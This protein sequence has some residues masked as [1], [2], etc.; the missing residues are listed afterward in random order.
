MAA[1]DNPL[2]QSLRLPP[3]A[4]SPPPSHLSL[5]PTNV[6]RVV[7]VDFTSTIEPT[8]RSSVQW[9]AVESAVVACCCTYAAVHVPLAVGDPGDDPSHWR[10]AADVITWI[11]FVLD[12]WRAKRDEENRRLEKARS[13]DA[14]LFEEGKNGWR[15]QF[16]L[17]CDAAAVVPVEPFWALRPQFRQG[18]EI[19][20]AVRVAKIPRCTVRCYA[21]GTTG[22]V[23]CVSLGLLWMTHVFTVVTIGIQT[24]ET[25]LNY[26][27]AFYWVVYTLTS[28][29][30]GDMSVGHSHS[31]LYFA[32][33]L[34]VLG[35][36]G[37]GLF[38]GKMA[39]LLA[40]QDRTSSDIDRGM[41]EMASLMDYYR[42]PAEL[43][44]ETL[45]WQ[46]HVLST[47][48]FEHHASAIQNLPASM[49]QR[50]ALCARRRILEAVPL[51]RGL[52]DTCLEDLATGLVRVTLDPGEFLCSRGEFASELFFLTHGMM[53]LLNAEHYSVG[54][55]RQGD[56]WGELGVLF[57]ATY[58][59]SVRAIG[60]CD[61]LGVPRHLAL[62]CCVRYPEFS[63]RLWRNVK[64]VDGAS[65]H[66][67]KLLIAE[68]LRSHRRAS[69]MMAAPIAEAQ[70]IALD[71][72]QEMT[73]EAEARGNEEH[74][75]TLGRMSVD[76]PTSAISGF[77]N[78]LECSFSAHMLRRQSTQG[79]SDVD[80]ASPFAG[81]RLSDPPS[82][83][84]ATRQ[85]VTSLLSGFK[86]PSMLRRYPAH[87]QTAERR[88]TNKVQD[89]DSDDDGEVSPV[90]GLH[91]ALG[92][93]R[94]SLGAA[95]LNTLALGASTARRDTA[96]A[97][98]GSPHNAVSAAV[99]Q[100]VT[101]A[102][103]PLLSEIKSLQKK[104]RTMEVPSRQR[105]ECADDVGAVPNEPET[106]PGGEEPGGRQAGVSLFSVMRTH[107][108][109][110]SAA[111]RMKPSV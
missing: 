106:S 33:F 8:R 73:A 67:D 60:Y 109:V 34:M 97:L 37:S 94:M 38:I 6:E 2:R 64:D 47:H 1:P 81:G 66:S 51:L 42:I 59:V 79:S 105:S 39:E 95:Q 35:L 4:S 99:T 100:A 23:V 75:R 69:E 55:I 65:A 74:T 90:S 36:F 49:Q 24:G 76:L 88:H 54:S 46:A 72:L 5:S 111:L 110:K 108:G 26:S 12:L 86:M 107:G 91:P 70:V 50:I 102:V 71:V 101:A 29:G 22:M 15:E 25:S 3:R 52:S 21:C 41:A 48:A 104:I 63:S 19:M 13:A 18:Y 92:D 57:G 93:Y 78:N 7:S 32:C 68:H 58:T 40:R 84:A 83:M 27:Q 31:A 16:L 20:R 98:G 103:A 10:L 56:I 82:P 11:V 61:S 30:Y 28:V 44:S 89:V 77:R 96:A 53:E 87:L 43:R 14:A 62:V 85:S 80:C 17:L 45:A 9:R